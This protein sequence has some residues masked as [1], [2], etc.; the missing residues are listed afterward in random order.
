MHTTITGSCAE[1]ED[2]IDR[3]RPIPVSDLL[4]LLKATRRRLVHHVLHGRQ[5][6]NGPDGLA[7]TSEECDQLAQWVPSFRDASKH[8]GFQ[9][10]I[11]LD[12]A[13]VS[14]VLKCEEA[15]MFGLARYLAPWAFL[16]AA[17][18]EEKVNRRTRRLFLQC[19]HSLLLTQ[20]KAQVE[21]PFWLSDQIRRGVNLCVAVFSILE[22]FP[23]IDIALGRIGS[24]SLECHFGIVRAVL[25][26]DDRFDRWLSAE[27]K[28]IMIGRFLS[29]L[30]VP[31]F[32]RRTRVAA[33]GAT[34]RA[35]N[36]LEPMKDFLPTPPFSC[37]SIHRLAMGWFVEGGGYVDVEE[38]Q[39]LSP[40]WWRGEFRA[41]LESLDVQLDKIS[42]RDASCNAGVQ[43]TGRLIVRGN[44]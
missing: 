32:R 6:V 37:A 40:E 13:Q 44:V 20:L 29:N 5:N 3:G 4:H 27:A 11:A 23:D 19:A 39:T 1:A 7:V 12:L 24:H 28:A 38:T 14:L 36:D 16:E 21:N 2:W 30:G 25:R 42:T 15:G 8:A 34:A 31:D 18:S 26:H 17:F 35:E 33:S 22:R 9:D 43:H 41:F 10:G